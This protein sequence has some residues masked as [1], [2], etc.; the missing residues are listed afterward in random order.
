MTA[1]EA[2]D[3]VEYLIRTPTASVQEGLQALEAAKPETTHE[4][5]V[6]AHS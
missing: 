4:Y 3:L 1:M 2:R 5:H 6:V